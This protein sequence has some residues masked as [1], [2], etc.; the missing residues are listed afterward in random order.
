M[1]LK[2]PERVFHNSWFNAVIA[3]GLHALH[4]LRYTCSIKNNIK[5]VPESDIDKHLI[6][7]LMGHFNFLTMHRIHI[8]LNLVLFNELRRK[9]FTMYNTK[10]RILSSSVWLLYSI[11]LYWR[12]PYA[13]FCL[14]I[15]K[16][17]LPVLF[18]I[19]ERYMQ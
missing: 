1:L 16:F 18:R 14:I 7:V 5:F 15:H 8:A 6:A 3:Y 11:S 19:T 17:I 12:D 2:D 13:C 9:G 10:H 4:K